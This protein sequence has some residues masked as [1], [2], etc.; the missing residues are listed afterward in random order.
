MRQ[1]GHGADVDPVLVDLVTV[2]ER[3]IGLGWTIM[4]P[5]CATRH[6]SSSTMRNDTCPSNTSH[7]LFE[8]D[9]KILHILRNTSFKH[10]PQY[11]IYFFLKHQYC[12]PQTGHS[13][14]YHFS[15][16][17]AIMV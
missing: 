14:F 10:V 9:L 17:G 11:G 4:T 16:V 1:A 3:H 6:S 7:P 15:E 12:A 13:M 5:N 8:S 2:F